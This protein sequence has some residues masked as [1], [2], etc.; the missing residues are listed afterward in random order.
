MLIL[1]FKRVDASKN[2][3]PWYIHPYRVPSLLLVP[4]SDVEPPRQ[5]ETVTF[6]LTYANNQNQQKFEIKYLVKFI[7]ENARNPLTL[8]SFLRDNYLDR[9]KK[10]PE[11]DEFDLSTSSKLRYDLINI[12]SNRLKSLHGDINYLTEMAANHSLKVDENRLGLDARVFKA[13]LNRL[14]FELDVMN[15][16]TNFFH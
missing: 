11:K 5:R 14:N 9:N 15:N 7:L 13:K 2:D 10:N 1:V 6:D 4:S 3:F 8:L 12:I 16:F